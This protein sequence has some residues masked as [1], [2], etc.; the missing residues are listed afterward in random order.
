V[1]VR[2]VVVRRVT[3][4]RPLTVRVLLVPALCALL[5]PVPAGVRP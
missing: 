3:T 4:R 1:T 2:V 5:V